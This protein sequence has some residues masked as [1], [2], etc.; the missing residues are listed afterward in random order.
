MLTRR[1]DF[2]LVYAGFGGQD[3]YHGKGRVEATGFCQSCDTVP[4]PLP[5]GLVPFP[6]LNEHS[7]PL[8]WSLFGLGN[9]GLIRRS[10][11]STV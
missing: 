11:R 5:A 8:L 2:L 6:V 9:L 4:L 7:K 10:A 3:G 1:V